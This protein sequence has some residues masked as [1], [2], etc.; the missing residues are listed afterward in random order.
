MNSFNGRWNE[1]EHQ[2]FL[3]GKAIDLLRNHETWERLETSLGNSENSYWI[4]SSISC[5]EV[6]SQTTKDTKIA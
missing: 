5:S 2:R 6:F 1:D 4:S 3:T